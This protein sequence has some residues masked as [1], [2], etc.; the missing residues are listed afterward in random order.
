MLYE[1]DEYH[2]TAP[3]PSPNYS[4]ATLYQEHLGSRCGSG[5]PMCHFRTQQPQQWQQSW[6]NSLQ[7]RSFNVSGQSAP[8]R[9]NTVSSPNIDFPRAA[10]RGPEP[11]RA[12]RRQA[13]PRPPDS[14][15]VDLQLAGRHVSAGEL[16][17]AVVAAVVG[18]EDAQEQRAG[19]GARQAEIRRLYARP[20]PFPS[21]PHCRPSSPGTPASLR[22]RTFSRSIGFSG[23]FLISSW[24]TRDST[25][26]FLL[27]PAR[28]SLWPPTPAAS[29]R[30]KPLARTRSRFYIWPARG[31]GVSQRRRT[32]YVKC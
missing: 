25:A 8:R 27:L 14:P 21:A 23:S 2:P 29:M 30:T 10:S 11:R 19:L 12:R 31:R 13:S 4:S 3:L 1:D 7:P 20:L 6:V 15:S 17:H 16:V 5:R 22:T 24:V 32:N 28:R 9:V 26:I 18:G